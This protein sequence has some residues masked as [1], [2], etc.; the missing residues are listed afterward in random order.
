MSWED[1]FGG[2]TA[3]GIMNDCCSETK[4]G[5]GAGVKFLKKQK[6]SVLPLERIELEEGGV[7]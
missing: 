6:R 5:V 3:S 4:C 2:E 7:C 1:S